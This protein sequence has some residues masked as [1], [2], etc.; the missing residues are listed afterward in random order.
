MSEAE[1][2]QICQLK[3]FIKFARSHLNYEGV[4]TV[5]NT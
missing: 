5:F 1:K 3:D 4:G 2:E